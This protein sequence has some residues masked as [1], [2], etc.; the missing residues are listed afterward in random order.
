LRRSPLRGTRRGQAHEVQEPRGAAPAPPAQGQGFM[1][2]NRSG[3]R[4]AQAQPHGGD[5]GGSAAPG[6][7]RGPG[8]AAGQVQVGCWRPR[9]R[10]VAAA[11]AGALGLWPAAAA[12]AD[13]VDHDDSCE[14]VGSESEVD[15][16]D[17]ERAHGRRSLDVLAAE[18]SQSGC[19][20][21]M[22]QS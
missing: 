15:D 10:A 13:A 20:W 4:E 6:A 5:R 18:V 14:M 22:R 19:D 9:R 21:M 7:P 16:D 8:A 12:A 2:R 11:L 17:G 3:L 1:L